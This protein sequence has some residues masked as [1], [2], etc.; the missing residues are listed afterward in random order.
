MQQIPTGAIDH[1]QQAQAQR[2]RQSRPTAPDNIDPPP[3]RGNSLPTFGGFEYAGSPS[4]NTSQ[5]HGGGSLQADSLQYQQGYA[6]DPSRQHTSQA[7]QQ[8][9][10]QSG[11]AHRIQQQQQYETNMVYNVTPQGQQQAPYAVA[12]NVQ[13][14]QSAAIEVLA[15]QFGVPPYLPPDAGG[16]ANVSGQYLAAQ[17]GPTPYSQPTSA[18]R[19]GVPTTYP[20]AMPEF[21]SA[22]TSESLEG[23][24]LPREE[25]KVDDAYNQYQ[26]TL[27]QTFEYTRTGHVVEA[28]QLLLEISDWLLTNVAELGTS[29]LSLSLSIYIY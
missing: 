6:P 10:D 11:L 4:Y 15:T 13:P 27:R 23:Q 28:S 18:M 7:T 12:S 22:V 5:F 9:P 3:S 1:F 2:A 8:H 21:N 17:V 25:P 20:E 24:N 16:G 14:R 29:L 26:Q 19:T